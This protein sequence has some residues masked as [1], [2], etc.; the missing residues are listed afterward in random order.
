MPS[1]LATAISED[2]T[3]LAAIDGYRNLLLWDIRKPNSAPVKFQIAVEGAL[4]KDEPRL[5]FLSSRIL[6]IALG[7]LV[8]VID[9][10]HMLASGTSISGI[11][12]DP[13]YLI[14]RTGLPCRASCMT[15]SD[16][17]EI[18]VGTDSGKIL[19]I[20]FAGRIVRAL[21][22]AC[23]DRLTSLMHVNSLCLI[24]GTQKGQIILLD[25]ST[26]SVKSSWWSPQPSASV[27]YLA[28]DA[29]GNWFSA[30]ISSGGKVN[31]VSGSTRS[32]VRVFESRQLPNDVNRCEFSYLTS[33]GLSILIGGKN[34]PLTVLPLDLSCLGTPRRS[35][36]E[37]S[38][39]GF[40]NL[41]KSRGGDLLSVT[42]NGAVIKLLAGTTLSFVGEIFV[43]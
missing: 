32:L 4:M 28:V 43:V 10:D 38:T 24:A 11:F 37:E 7:N 40:D 14:S 2:S 1:L 12:S 27:N 31:L 29:K 6:S 19:G 13:P 42:C 16:S 35:H 34:T 39:V 5:L 18:L 17:D 15:S 33:S 22:T 8:I 9:S 36:L 23:E 20:S 21:Q 30:L 25:P 26:G 41:C 3:K